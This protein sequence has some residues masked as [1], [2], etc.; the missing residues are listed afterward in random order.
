M[1]V[2]NAASWLPRWTARK[3]LVLI[4]SY[5]RPHNQIVMSDTRVVL[6]KNLNPLVESI[7]DN[8]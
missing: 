7:V 3:L 6:M 1:I 8:E 2:E 5:F 4:L